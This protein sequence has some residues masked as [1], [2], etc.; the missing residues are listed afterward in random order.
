MGSGDLDWD[1]NERSLALGGFS[2]GYFSTLLLGGLLAER[3]DAKWVFGLGVFLT[4]APALAAPFLANLDVNAFIALRAFQGAAQG[5]TLPAMYVLNAKWLP[6]PEKTRL[7]TFIFT[8]LHFGTIL[9]FPISGAIA[10][11]AGWEGIF[12]T[13]GSFGCIWFVFWVYFCHESPATHPAIS[14]VGKR[15]Y[16]TSKSLWSSPKI[17]H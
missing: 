13:F 4:S 12:Y 14:Q 8:G 9:G 10:E 5:P 7:F 15:V 17:S 2:F 1:H 11:H 16:T 3:F 6:T